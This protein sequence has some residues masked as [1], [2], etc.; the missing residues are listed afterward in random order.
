LNKLLRKE[1]SWEWM[2]E[3]QNA[4]DTLKEQFM[5]N[6]ILTTPNPEQELRIESDAS[7]FAT[8]AVLS[9]KCEDE[10]WRP[11]TYYSKLLSDV[12]RNYDVHDKEMLSIMRALEQW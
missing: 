7:D 6:P 5:T 4:F 1:Q 10:K 9:T 12:E 3:Q 2:M 11:C 8:G